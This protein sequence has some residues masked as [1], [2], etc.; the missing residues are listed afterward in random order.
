MLF[1]GRTRQGLEPVR[2]VRCTAIHRPTLH[3]VGHIAGNTRVKRNAFI[4]RCK[5]FLAN[6]LREVRA[7]GLGIENIFA[8]EIDVHG[9][10]RHRTAHRRSCDIIDGL[11][12][13]I[14]HDLPAFLF[15]RGKIS[16]AIS[17]LHWRKR[18]KIRIFHYIFVKKIRFITFL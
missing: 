4:N 6:I 9:S 1:G 14:V 18:I 11:I 13:T 16:N 15:S 3:G 17:Y 2:K 7:H 12:T 8:I 10:S 5:K